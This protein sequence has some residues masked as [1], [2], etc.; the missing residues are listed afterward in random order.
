MQ[1]G[2]HATRA[3]S[4]LYMKWDFKVIK[5]QKNDAGIEVTRGLAESK[6]K[7]SQWYQSIDI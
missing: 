1:T 4:V 2:Y 6:I 7:M 3:C 5:I